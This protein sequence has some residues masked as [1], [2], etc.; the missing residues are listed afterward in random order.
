MRR[1]R[2][3]WLIGAAF[4]L[5]ALAPSVTGFATDWMWFGEVG[6]DP[7]PPSSPAGGSG[8]KAT[9]PKPPDFS[10]SSSVGRRRFLRKCTMPPE[11]EPP[12][13]GGEKARTGLMASASGV[14]TGD[15]TRVE[16]PLL[17]DARG[18]PALTGIPRS[19]WLRLHA[20]DENGRLLVG[21]DVAIAVWRLTPGEAW[22]AALTGNAVTRPV[23]RFVYDR[24]ADILYAW[25][26]RKRHW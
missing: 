25:N 24:F 1:F 17:V 10:A 22:L 4:I 6:F 21:A 23:T 3:L 26:R 8:R 9:S 7:L 5:F 11:S 12:L 13:A 18:V 2:V 14:L 19:T 15:A 20:T 16:Y